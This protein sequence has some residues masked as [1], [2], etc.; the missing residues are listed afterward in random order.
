[1]PHFVLLYHDCPPSYVRPSHWD[2]MLEWGG[3]LETWAL[4][5]LP[6]AFQAAHEH[7]KIA[8][9]NCPPLADVDTVAA[10][11]LAGHRLEFL[12]Y[13][14]ALNGDRG[15][16]QRIASGTSFVVTQ[17]PDTWRLRLET[18]VLHG[19]LTLERVAAGAAT[20]QAIAR[21]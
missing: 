15:Q 14:G 11:H 9:P 1:M 7:T 4:F 12:E 16:V 19:E 2:L 10:E 13:E 5:Q 18:G 3:V 6:R 20:W 8:F 21:S 17:S